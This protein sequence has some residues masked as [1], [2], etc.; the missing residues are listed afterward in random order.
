[1]IGRVVVVGLGPAGPD[2]VTAATAAA[3]ERITTRFVR[4][5][6]HPAVDVVEPATSFDE[7]Y[8][9]ASTLDD[10]YRTIVDA[11]VAS[12]DTNGE[13]LY[14]VPGSPVVAE[15]T[16]ALLRDAAAAGRIELEV[17]PALSFVDLAWARLGVDPVASGARIVDGHRFAV[18][19][20]GVP[21]P[22]LVAQ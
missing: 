19:A 9:Q 14:A 5:T 15:R 21:G 2:L 13:I 20:A 11:L 18:E 17:L 1:M 8:E 6:R 22:L 7:V 16:V 3:I 4:T 10:V 12:A